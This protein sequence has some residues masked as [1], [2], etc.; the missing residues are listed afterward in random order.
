MFWD[1]SIELTPNSSMCRLPKTAFK[2][3]ICDALV[4]I[5]DAEDMCGKAPNLLSKVLGKIKI[6]SMKFTGQLFSYLFSSFAY[7]FSHSIVFWWSIS[8]WMSANLCVC[9]HHSVNNFLS[10]S[11]LMNDMEAWPTLIS[12]SY[13]QVV[14][15]YITVYVLL[16]TLSTVVLGRW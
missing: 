4:L 8:M 13:L 9:L 3:K 1:Q 5:F 11:W 10:Y 15:D 6:N 2:R 16:K 14:Q 7:L 12:L